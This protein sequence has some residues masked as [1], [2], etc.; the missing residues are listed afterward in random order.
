[1]PDAPAREQIVRNN[2]NGLPVGDL[3]LGRIAEMTEGYNAADV[4]EFCDRMKLSAV[5]RSMASGKDETIGMSDAEFA[6]GDMCSSVDP[7][8]LKRLEE[9]SRL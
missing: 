2:M 1:M 8:D 6:S 9:F 7:R 4:V 3:D 5:K